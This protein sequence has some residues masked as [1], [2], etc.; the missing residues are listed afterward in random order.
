MTF[1]INN[2]ARYR[3]RVVAL[4]V[5]VLFAGACATWWIVS[6]TDREMRDSLLLETRLVAEGVNVGRIAAL[7]GTE[8]DRSNPAYQ[9]I[10]EQLAATRS[11]HPLCRFAYLLGRKTDGTIFFLVDSE[12]AD[13]KDSSPPGQIYEEATESFSQA[14]TSG[15]EVVEGPVRD[16]WGNWVSALVP[17]Y[18]PPTALDPAGGTVLA[19]FGMDIDARNWTRMLV[20]SGLPASLLTLALAA[21]IV[22]GSVLLKDRFCGGRR[23]PRSFSIP[24]AALVATAGTALSLFAAWMRH[25]LET[26]DREEAFGRLAASRTAAITE[27]LRTLRDTEL[28]GLAHFCETNPHATAEEFRHYTAYLTKNPAVQAWAWVPVVKETDKSSFEAKARGAGWQDYGIWQMDGDKKRVPAVGRNFY[29]PVFQV[30][31][32]AGNERAVGYDTG[33][34]PRRR[35]AIEEAARTGLPT[36]TEP[37]AL[38]QGESGQNGMLMYRPV[39]S[40]K[41]PERLLGF[42]VALVRMN[43]LLRSEDPA[44]T[45]P[46][47]LFLLRKNAPPELLASA[48]STGIQHSDA[49]SVTRPIFAFGKVFAV[50]IH[51]EREFTLFARHPGRASIEALVIGLFLTSALAILTGVLLRRREELVRLLAEMTKN[52]LIA[53]HARDPLILVT[54]DGSVV[55]GNRAAEKLYGYSRAELLRLRIGDLRAGEDPESVRRQMEQAMKHGVL[56]ETIHV[57]RDGTTVPVEVNSQGILFDGQ[58]MLLSV[59]RDI[60]ERRGTERRIARLTQLYA[61]LTRCNQDIV[62]SNSPEELFPKICRAVVRLGGMKMAWIGLIDEETGLVRPATSFGTGTEYLDGIRISVNPDEPAGQGPTGTAIRNNQPFWCQDFMNDPATAPWQE[63]GKRFGWASDAALPLC[64]RGKPIGALMIYSDSVQAFDDDVKSLLTGMADDISFALESF[65]AEDERRRAEKSLQESEDRHRTILHTAMDGFC[66]VDEQGCLREVNEAYCRM[67]GYTGNELL[68]MRITDLDANMTPDVV[69]ASIQT[70]IKNGEARFES[71]QRRKD[72]SLFD[73]EVS[74][75]YRAAEKMLVSFL[76]DITARKQSQ[77]AIAEAYEALEQRVAERTEELDR[78]R[79]HLQHLLDTAPVGVGI[80]VDGIVRFA[81][82]RITEIV[83]L[84]IG[85][86]ASCIYCDLEDRKR[87]LQLL[88]QQEIVRDWEFK[89]NGPNGEIRDTMATFLRT[90]YDGGR[91]ILCWLVD[92]SKIKTAESEMRAAK[93]LAEEASKAKS[94]FLANMSHEIR[95]PMNA[96]LGFSQLL[97]HDSHLAVRQKKHLETINRSGEHLLALI[98]DILDMSKIEAGRVELKPAPLDLSALLHDLDTMF[99]IRTDTKGLRLDVIKNNDL[100]QCCVAD[101]GKLLQ[102]LINLLGNAVKFTSKGGIVLRV[103]LDDCRPPRLVFEV[104]DTGIGIPADLLGSLFQPFVQVHSEHH[105]GTIH[106]TGLGLAISREI[107]HLMGGDISVTSSPGKGSTF[108]FSIP[109]VEGKT[110]HA[111]RSTRLHRVAG[112]KPG[113]PAFRILIVDDMEDNRALLTEM[114]SRAGFETRASD[115]GKDAPG[116][117]EEWHPHLILMDMRMPSMG[118]A[119]AIRRIRAADKESGVKIISLTANTFASM[120]REALDAGADDFL[121]KPF[122]EVELFE[123]IRLL[124]GVE[125]EYDPGAGDQVSAA[126]A[127]LPAAAPEEL[128]S[129]PADLVRQIRD[130]AVAADYDRLLELLQ[131]VAP[132]SKN[133]AQSLSAM[134]KC[135][136]YQQLLDVLN[137]K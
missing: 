10:K 59:I 69:A 117:C 52:Q 53:Q 124:I 108:R 37:V 110:H 48:G 112:I 98:N 77:I 133:L 132:H 76:H 136:N 107:A 56:F 119:D 84:K 75:Q 92:I 44:P 47:Q 39:F 5:A 4:V 64:A 80:S 114:L 57:R 13:S 20:L 19:A 72:G 88:E 9:Q 113:Q 116:I 102:V 29:Y 25:D 54:L 128:A 2:P 85:E 99:R 126:A 15:A 129:L 91:G 1:R 73:V 78:Q 51:P 135:Y 87:I 22:A 79:E 104:E 106:G 7:S 74:V 18:R 41:N 127:A 28:E 121:A 70:I 58:E 27:T 61:A 46:M 103:S 125:Y 30:A 130:A 120:R 3:R 62:H 43:T 33:S 63:F 11:T 100:P 35:A 81:N 131:S 21:I 123:K 96:I 23:Q 101:K 42:A 38:V 60:T 83:N 118:G 89:M 65:A 97:L 86:P 36:A 26:H 105:P 71:R 14:F 109:L 31:P 93:E 50:T 40:M 17:I 82:P 45:L 95:T 49:H 8:A 6:Q 24:A 16:R 122:R 12:P 32:L 34:E 55:D 67:T 68:T 66:L 134:V 90:E 111:E 137:T 94:A 115:S